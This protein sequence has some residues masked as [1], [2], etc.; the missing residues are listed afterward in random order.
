MNACSSQFFL[1][2]DQ[3]QRGRYALGLLV[4]PS[5]R[6]VQ[7]AEVLVGLIA[8]ELALDDGSLATEQAFHLAEVGLE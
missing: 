4:C 7:R 3:T 2:L 6:P 5:P 8:A 1:G